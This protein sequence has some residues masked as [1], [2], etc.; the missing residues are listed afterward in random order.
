MGLIVKFEVTCDQ[1]AKT[2]IFSLHG[3]FI[4]D[5]GIAMPEGWGEHPN[6][7]DFLFC[8]DCLKEHKKLFPEFYKD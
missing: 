7:E 6:D 4:D 8:P 3:N 5:T 2:I 1:C